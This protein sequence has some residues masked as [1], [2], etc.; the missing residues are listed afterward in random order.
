LLLGGQVDGRDEREMRGKTSDK[1]V[2]YSVAPIEGDDTSP[3]QSLAITKGASNQ[4]IVDVII[5]T[6]GATVVQRHAR[7]KVTSL[8]EEYQGLLF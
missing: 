8:I 6:P 7:L 4:S 1:I 2:P 5:L 3:C